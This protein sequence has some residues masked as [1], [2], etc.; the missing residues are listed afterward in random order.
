MKDE[1]RRRACRGG[2]CGE[3]EGARAPDEL[4]GLG[5]DLRSVWLDA[6]VAR[7]GAESVVEL[8]WL[9]NEL[10]EARPNGLG[11]AQRL[12]RAGSEHRE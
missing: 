2:E 3:E 6:I 12:V 9:I 8:A 7:E 5:E 4:A 11:N 1:K 10:L